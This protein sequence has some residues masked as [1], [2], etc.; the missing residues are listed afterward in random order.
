MAKQHDK[1]TSS[2]LTARIDELA[3][4]GEVFRERKNS[5]VHHKEEG[6]QPGTPSTSGSQYG[7]RQVNH[8]QREE[9]LPD[10][11]WSD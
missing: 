10:Y 2:A 6:P 11:G 9:D 7:Q 4:H 8:S 3:P 5:N 1:L